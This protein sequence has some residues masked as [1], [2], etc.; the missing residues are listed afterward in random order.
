MERGSGLRE[1]IHI[2]DFSFKSGVTLVKF[3]SLFEPQLP[4]L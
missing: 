4:H 1:R 3:L 2:S